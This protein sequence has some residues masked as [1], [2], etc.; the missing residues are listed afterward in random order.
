[1]SSENWTKII[2]ALSRAVV[3]VKAERLPGPDANI[4]PIRLQPR[5]EVLCFQQH[6]LVA[7]CTQKM[8]KLCSETK[9]DTPAQRISCVFVC[10]FLLLQ[11]EMRGEVLQLSSQL[12]R[13]M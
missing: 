5:A 10:I 8:R 2:A 11:R 12:R 9:T 7:G 13:G 3:F 4:R 1:V 6:D